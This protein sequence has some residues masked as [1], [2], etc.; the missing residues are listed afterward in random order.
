MS[1]RCPAVTFTIGAATIVTDRNTDFKKGD[2]KDL[3]SGRNVA[4]TGKTQPT[5]SVLAD[6]I[7]FKKDNED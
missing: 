1:G 5:L 7:E 3:K 6:R 2:C 4:V